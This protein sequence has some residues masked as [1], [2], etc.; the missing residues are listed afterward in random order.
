[1]LNNEQQIKCKCTIFEELFKLIKGCFSCDYSDLTCVCCVVYAR[2]N[3]SRQ[4]L[5]HPS[6]YQTDDDNDSKDNS[7]VKMG[8]N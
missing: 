8:L 1:M 6:H 3:E 7:P 5:A 4:S 2:S